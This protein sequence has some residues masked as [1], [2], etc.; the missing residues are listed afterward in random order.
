M[1]LRKSDNIFHPPSG[2]SVPGKDEANPYDFCPPEEIRK[3]LEKAT[4]KEKIE[5]MKSSLRKWERIYQYPG[6]P[7]RVAGFLRSVARRILAELGPAENVP[8]YRDQEV[9]DGLESALDGMKNLHDQE[10]MP[11]VDYNRQGERPLVDVDYDSGDFL[12]VTDPVHT[13]GVVSPR[14]DGPDPDGLECDYPPTGGDS[15]RL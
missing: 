3:L 5:K 7:F 10:D 14:G 13:P 4:D 2:S 11:R 9:S 6:Y 12:T 1:P 15:G 8:Y